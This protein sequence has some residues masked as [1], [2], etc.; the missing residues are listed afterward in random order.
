M[1]TK[2]Y[3][4][5]L[6]ALLILFISESAGGQVYN[7]AIGATDVTIN[8]ILTISF[9]D[10]DDIVL[11]RD[12]RGNFEFTIESDEDFHVISLDDPE[13]QFED[14]LLTIDLSTF[15]LKNN[16]LYSVYHSTGY[17]LIN[18]VDFDEIWDDNYWIFTTEAS[19]PPPS[20]ISY[21]PIPNTTGVLINQSLEIEFNEEIKKGTSGSIHIRYTSDDSDFTTFT[22]SNNAVQVS[23][24][25]VT[26][27]PPN[28]EYNTDY[29]VVIEN[30]YILN[31]NDVAFGGI[32]DPSDWNFTTETLMPTATFSPEDKSDGISV[33]SIVSIIYSEGVQKTDGTDLT[34]ADLGSLITLQNEG[35]DIPYTAVVSNDK[36]T[37]TITPTSTLPQYEKITTTI[38]PLKGITGGG[39]TA[40]LSSYFTTDG[41]VTWNGSV[42]SDI[43]DDDNWTGTFAEGISVHIPLTTNNPEVSSGS[44][45]VRN[46]KIDAGAALTVTS[47]AS[48]TVAKEL[49]LGSSIDE[50]IGNAN[51]LLNGT[52]TTTDANVDIQ[53][54]IARELEGLYI[55]PPITG[56]T[57]NNSN[58]TNSVYRRNAYSGGTW[59]LLGSN[60]AMTPGEGYIA[61]GSANEVISFNG[62][63]NNS[64][65]GPLDTYR[66]S[67]PNN[68]GWNLLGNPFPCGIDWDF[69]ELSS[70][71]NPHVYILDNL[72]G[73]FAVY[74][75]ADD[76]GGDPLY[77][78]TIGSKPSYIPSC[79]A[80]WVQVNQSETQGTVTIPLNSRVISNNSYL[81]S[82][83]ASNGTTEQIRFK[84]INSN[85]IADDYL[86]AFKES[87]DNNNYTHHAERRFSS[88]AEILQLYTVAEDKNFVIDVYSGYNEGQTI[89]VG[90]KIGKEGTYKI[91]LNELK[92]IEGEIDITLTDKVSEQEITLTQGS[93]Y[94]FYTKNGTFNERF[95]IEIK[96]STSTD[97]KE[98]KD[99]N[100]PLIYSLN[101]S[102]YI[103]TPSLINPSCIIYDISGRQIHAQQLNS[104]TMNNFIVDYYGIV[105]VRVT[106]EK[107]SFSQKIY[108]KK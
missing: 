79:H 44:H 62:T 1:K 104:D 59:E 54:L 21:N 39:E 63:I 105:I 6:V 88:N 30:G 102:V 35:I 95:E 5:I 28:F 45:Y 67:S 99:D 107:N 101:N 75:P 80:F 25:T 83:T 23:G 106:S 14:N 53:Q 89:N 84:G 43:S 103:N 66:T 49:T 7:P 64:E 87:A 56:A 65:V 18:D 91:Q 58:I 19:L 40:W 17:I 11:E 93:E 27:N 29:Y 12:R 55:S 34:D 31:T 97:N 85:N 76:L 86:I 71:M 3:L 73:I 42:S 26:I 38:A 72:T 96:P 37:I 10:V 20:I 4:K 16:K 70:E 22:T 57:M 2:T 52:L 36:T 24:N 82:T 78:N 108:L 8:P 90:Y 15:S 77:V 61:Y 33:Y 9:N 92:N 50:N 74:T 68:Y 46:L 47:G 48:I 13:M 100:K 69:V 60:E 81:K 32:S 51:L 94:E 98:I 41:L